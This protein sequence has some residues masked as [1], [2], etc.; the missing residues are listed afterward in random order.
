M[1]EYR[2]IER[3]EEKQKSH[4]SAGKN[5][6]QMLKAAGNQSV[7]QMMGAS[8]VVQCIRV[9]DARDSDWYSALP[10]KVRE[11]VEEQL[12]DTNYSSENDL[13]T[14]INEVMAEMH[15][16]AMADFI[17]TKEYGGAFRPRKSSGSISSSG[18]N[19]WGAVLMSAFQAGLITADQVITLNKSTPISEEAKNSADEDLQ[20]FMDLSDTI[21]MNQHL[22]QVRDDI[23]KGHI[24]GMGTNFI[25]HVALS[26]G[27]VDGKQSALEFDAGH[28]GSTTLDDMKAVH[29]L[30]YEGRA[31]FAGAPPW[32]L[33]IDS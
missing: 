10:E 17:E 12:G 25:D 22:H 11:K 6:A 8:A 9:A 14:A 13:K 16:E 32:F 20:D 4:T 7:L 30:S 28:K 15:L 3:T 21:T 31:V 26:R 5:A 18:M 19:C 27:K 1:R 33:D 24:I 29:A 2:R 23:P